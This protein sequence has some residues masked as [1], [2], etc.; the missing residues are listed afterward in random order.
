MFNPFGGGV[1]RGWAGGHH[2]NFGTPGIN[3]SPSPGSGLGGMFSPGSMGNGGGFTNQLP[4]FNGQ[5]PGM[6]GPLPPY[7][8]G[9]ATGAP[10]GGPV[11]PGDTGFS[12]QPG[13]MPMPQP[14]GMPNFPT[15]GATNWKPWGG[16]L[17]GRVTPFGR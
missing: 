14:G 11:N 2:E 17:L 9:M 7:N 10:I 5:M 13:Q 16:P 3:V 15:N 12:M 1:S 8:P 6:G 4:R